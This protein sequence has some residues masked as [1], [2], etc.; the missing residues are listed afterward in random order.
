MRF[1][2]VIILFHL[3]C[4][5]SAQSSLRFHGNG[6]NAPD[7]DRVKIPIDDP[8]NNNPGPPADIG[9]QDFTIEFWLKGNGTDNPSSSTNCG[10]N[11]NWIYG[12]IILDRDR[13]NQD[14][15]FGV[16]VAGGFLIFGVSG[17][18]TGNRT[19][20]SASNLLD[21]EWHHIALQRR[22]SDGYLWMYIDGILE[23]DADGPG[24]DISYP[25]DGTPCSTCCGGNNCNQSDPY[26]VLGAEKHDAG[27]SYP[28]FSGF[29]DELRLSS[30]LRYTGNFTVPTSPFTPDMH[31][32]ALY[33]FDEGG[34]STLTDHS[35][36][37]G[38]PSNGTVVYGGNPAGPVWST[39]TPFS[40]STAE[41]S[42]T[43]SSSGDWHQNGANWSLNH[44]PG[45]CEQVVINPGYL[46]TISTGSVG[47]CGTLYIMLGTTFIVES[48]GQLEV[49]W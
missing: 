42:W 15:K 21:D 39:D 6:V 35:G 18:G 16:S 11:I 30:A 47:Q 36:A 49:G 46:I 14:R 34:G 17:D 32:A 9:S 43:G 3:F 13:Y 28:S 38:G 5:A 27:A 19:I 40:C 29:L 7:Q 33:H 4:C 44:I 24:G 22:R 41:N 25:D 8:G 26:L 1:A 48:G 23:S 10:A 12:N 37:T 45:R 20:C 2:F 31:T